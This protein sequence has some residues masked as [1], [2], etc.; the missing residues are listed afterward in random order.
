MKAS[1]SKL[2]WVV[3]YKTKR[4]ERITHAYKN[5]ERAEACAKNLHAVAHLM[6]YTDIQNPEP[7]VVL[8]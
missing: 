8:S 3:S 5:H 1:K 2:V 4:N 7:V 6:E